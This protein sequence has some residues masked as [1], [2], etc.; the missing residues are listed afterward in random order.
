M[1]LREAITRA[2]LFYRKSSRMFL[3]AV[4]LASLVVIPNGSFIIS[5]GGNGSPL[6][7]QQQQQQ[8]PSPNPTFQLIVALPLIN[9][10]MLGT[11][12]TSSDPVLPAIDGMY[13][14]IM[15]VAF[16]I[17]GVSVIVEMITGA[18]GKRRQQGQE[19]YSVQFLFNIAAGVVIILI[20]PM[21]MIHC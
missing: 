18:L 13:N 3:V 21:Y 9:D 15:I 2:A 16:I 10:S 12:V 6:A 14:F 11:N 17:L 7:G 20:F 5:G 8:L 1:T 19:G 4:L